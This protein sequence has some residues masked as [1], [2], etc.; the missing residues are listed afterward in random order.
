MKS[1]AGI[2]SREVPKE[3]QELIF[4]ISR[5]LALEDWTLF[6]GGAIGCDFTFENGCDDVCGKKKIF[7]PWKDF[8]KKWKRKSCSSD[9]CSP[10]KEAISLVKDL[11]NEY[12]DYLKESNDWYWLLLGRNMHQILGEDLKKPVKSVIC[13]TTNA[14][15]VGGTRWAIRIAKKF[16]IEILNLGKIETKNRFEKWLNIQKS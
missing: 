14:Q 9:I 1:Y 13:Y 4:K 10:S 6:S 7:L 5:K 11:A 12:G 2:G 8:G 16:N 15:E 3:I